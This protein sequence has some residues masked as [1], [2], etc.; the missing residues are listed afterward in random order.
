MPHNTL[1]SSD[2]SRN[3]VVG[4]ALSFLSSYYDTPPA[5]ITAFVDH[6]WL[7]RAGLVPSSAFSSVEL[8]GG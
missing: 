1:T 8:Y 3:S 7:A 4:I 6:I 2:N 5:D